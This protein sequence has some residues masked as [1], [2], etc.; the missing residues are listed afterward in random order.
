MWKRYKR[1]IVTELREK[2]RNFEWVGAEIRTCSD[3]H[4]KNEQHSFLSLIALYYYADRFT[5]CPLR[6]ARKYC[7]PGR[8]VEFA[9][10]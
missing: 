9:L 10:D 6:Q 5:C 8:Y 1:D 3:V 2:E 7:M 4:Y